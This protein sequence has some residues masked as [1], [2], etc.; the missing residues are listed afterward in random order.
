M[1]WLKRAFGCKWERL[2]NPPNWIDSRARAMC[3]ETIK[4][5]KG[6]T[7]LD[8]REYY[9]NEANG[10]PTKR[11]ITVTTPGAFQDLLQA[12]NAN[13]DEILD[14]LATPRKEIQAPRCSLRRSKQI[15]N[16]E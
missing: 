8:I 14:S 4:E 15:L 13:K 3:P 1:N 2:K 6:R 9:F 16:N 12:L 7:F 5:Y 10:T 11:G